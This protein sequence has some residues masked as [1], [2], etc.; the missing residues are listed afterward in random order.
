MGRKLVITGYIF[1]LML[2]ILG[3][4]VIGFSKEII[5]VFVTSVNVPL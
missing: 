5:H 1:G 2:A 3:A 4:L